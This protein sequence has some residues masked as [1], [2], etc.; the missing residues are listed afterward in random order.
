MLPSNS[1]FPQL[2]LLSLHAVSGLALLLL[3]LCPRFSLP[4][5]ISGFSSTGQLVHGC[6]HTEPNLPFPQLLPSRQMTAAV[7]P[8][9]SQP[10]WIQF[11]VVEKTKC[12]AQLQCNYLCLCTRYDAEPLGV[13]AFSSSSQVRIPA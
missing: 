9:A 5:Q 10:T 13:P 11:V 12:I 3:F 1:P 4:S 2:P 6:C 7:N 8:L